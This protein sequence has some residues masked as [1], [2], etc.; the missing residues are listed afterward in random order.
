[1]VRSTV[2]VLLAQILRSKGPALGMELSPATDRPQ[3]VD[4]LCELLSVEEQPSAGS[5]VASDLETVAPDLS[6]VPLD[7]VLEFRERHLKQYRAYARSVREFLRSIEGIPIDQ[8]DKAFRDREEEIR[9]LAS[10]LKQ[11]GRKAWKRP[12]S[13]ALSIAGAAWTAKTGDPL[14]AFLA[15]AGAVTGLGSDSETEMSAYSYLFSARDRF[16]Y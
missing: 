10:D 7:E 6:L 4:A 13:F 11:V 15:A 12:A 9:E 14:G 16:Y 5:V 2:L 1:M 3:L 8:R